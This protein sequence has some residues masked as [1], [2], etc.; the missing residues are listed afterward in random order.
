MN[1][2][3]TERQK[4]IKVIHDEHKNNIYTYILLKTNSRNVDDIMQDVFKKMF[5]FLNTYNEELSVFTTWMY[6]LINSVISDFY[7]TDHTEHY[8]AVSD[9][10]SNDGNELVQFQFPTTESADDRVMNAELKAR[11]H[12]AFRNLKPKYRNI[13]IMY[14][15]KE[16][17][18]EEI[19]VMQKL[20]LGTVK[21]MISRCRAMLKTEL[22]DLYNVKKKLE[23]A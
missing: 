10:V 13:G 20:S 5:R 17:K 14:F 22:N 11:L 18:Y 9:F 7:R 3:I 19:A 12:K 6:N 16:Y 15:V 4:E 23:T 21:G 8:T 2:T 1:M